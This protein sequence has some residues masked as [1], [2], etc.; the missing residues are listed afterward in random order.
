MGVLGWS[1]DAF[2][3]ATIWDA[4]HAF[5]G[6]RRVNSKVEP[7]PDLTNADAMARRIRAQEVEARVYAQRG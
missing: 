2:W 7:Q 1:P 4:Q 5:E 6:W 3:N